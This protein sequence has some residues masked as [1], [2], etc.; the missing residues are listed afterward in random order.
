M[1][2]LIFGCFFVLFSQVAF[3]GWFSASGV[4]KAEWFSLS[5]EERLATQK[6]WSKKWYYLSYDQRQVRLAEVKKYNNKQFP[7]FKKWDVVS[8]DSSADLK[9]S[10]SQEEVQ[11]QLE[12]EKWIKQFDTLGKKNMSDTDKFVRRNK[13]LY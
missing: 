11:I 1:K 5:K 6:A 9:E 10:P 13:T 7:H 4:D 3:A 12:R 8:F 2:S